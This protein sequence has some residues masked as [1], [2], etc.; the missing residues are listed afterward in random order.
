[1][2]LYR[3]VIDTNVLVSALRSRRGASFELLRRLQLDTYRA[4][5]TVP[6][7]MEYAD[8]LHRDGM[9]P[10]AAP[11]IDAVIDML[12][13]KADTQTVFFLWR[14]QLRDPNDEMVLEAAVN[15]AAD[16]LITHNGR[17]FAAANTFSVRVIT[18]SEFLNLLDG[19]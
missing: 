13:A 1:M 3:I 18:P 11:A 7:L 4:V 10:I 12:C 19:A 14:P 15:G 17:D 16:F 5:V 6:L 9:V 2:N 8:V